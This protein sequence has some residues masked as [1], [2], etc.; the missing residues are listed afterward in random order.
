[1]TFLPVRSPQLAALS[2]QTKR[3]MSLNV[4]AFHNDRPGLILGRPQGPD[5]A[6]FAAVRMWPVSAAQTVCLR[7]RYEG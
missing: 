7:V 3:A 2:Y 4:F 6:D 5:D 1:M